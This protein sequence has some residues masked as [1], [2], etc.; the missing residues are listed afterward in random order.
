MAF[1]EVWVV[2]YAAVER[3][4]GLVPSMTNLCGAL[5]REIRC[6]EPCTW[7]A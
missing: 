2:E 3:D 7:Q 5:V 6:D 4:G 1:L